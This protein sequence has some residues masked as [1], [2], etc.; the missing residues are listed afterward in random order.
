MT[1][2]EVTTDVVIVGGGL[3]GLTLAHLLTKL[4]IDFVLVEGRERLGGRVHTV[5]VEGGARVEMGATWRFCVLEKHR[6]H[7][8]LRLL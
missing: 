1:M 7:P 4:S 3:T 5:T 2:A 8:R 6:P